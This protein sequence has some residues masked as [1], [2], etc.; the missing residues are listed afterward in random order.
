[1]IYDT[2]TKDIIAFLVLELGNPTVT[3]FKNFLKDCQGVVLMK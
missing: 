2:I 1:M 3:D